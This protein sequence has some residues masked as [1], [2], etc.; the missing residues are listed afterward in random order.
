MV[1]IFELVEAPMVSSRN[2]RKKKPVLT[3]TFVKMGI[4]ELS[5]SPAMVL[6]VRNKIINA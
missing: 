1:L 3:E 6:P 2:L 5:V 4:D